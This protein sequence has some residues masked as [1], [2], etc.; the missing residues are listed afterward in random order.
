MLAVLEGMSD[1]YNGIH[2]QRKIAEPEPEAKSGATFS[3]IKDEDITFTYCTEFI[4]ERRD[5]SRNVQRLRTFLNSI[6][7]S[8]VVVEDDD[9][10]KV[11]VHTDQPNEALEAGLKF[12]QLLTVK[13]ENMRQQHS[14][15]I[16]EEAAGLESTA[17][18]IAEPEKKYGFVSV[19]AGDGLVNVFKDLGVDEMVQG[20]QTMNP[21]TDDILHAIDAVP[22]EIVYVLP[23]NKNI[24]MA[25]E[26]AV[27]LCEKKTVV[28]IPTKNIPQGISALLSFDEGA[29]MDENR[30]AMLD[31]AANVRS[32]QITYAAR[33]L[34]ARKSRK[35]NTLLWLSPSCAQT[36]ASWMTPSK[37]CCVKC[38]KRIPR[39]SISFTVRT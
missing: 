33:I 1:A 32:G 30:E 28:I 3:D 27:P 11:H 5:K 31:A 8:L 38:A 20:G 12:G 19:A 7:D 17:R 34:T 36:A 10:I 39:L 25:A 22:A 2:K 18:K 26:Q 16:V 35:A 15:K 29:E 37:R 4:A 6:G 23:N 21:S 24:I 14:A 9:I 13:I